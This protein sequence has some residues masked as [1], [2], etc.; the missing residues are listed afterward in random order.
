MLKPITA[1]LEEVKKTYGEST[2][3][4]YSDFY[5]ALYRSN[6]DAFVKESVRNGFTVTIEWVREY[7]PNL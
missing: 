2:R 7:C 5:Y 1:H 6:I 4:A 3:K